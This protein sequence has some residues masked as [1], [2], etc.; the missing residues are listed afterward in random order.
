RHFLLGL[1]EAKP[2]VF[3]GGM[4]FWVAGS[5]RIFVFARRR[6]FCYILVSAYNHKREVFFNDRPR[7]TRFLLVVCNWGGH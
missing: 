6:R 2:N 5:D 7:Q 4:R 1:A 3:L